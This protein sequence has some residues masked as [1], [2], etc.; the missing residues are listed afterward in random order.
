MKKVH[1][2]GGL[3]MLLVSV[4]AQTTVFG[5]QT[6]VPIVAESLVPQ[7]RSTIYGTVYGD[8]RRPVAE[9]YVELLD[10]V[11]STIRQVKTDYSGRFQFT[12]LVDGRYQVKIRPG[13]T[14]YMEHTSEVT[15][16]AVSSVRPSEG[17][18]SGGSDTQHLEIVLKLN[19]RVIAGP[20]AA[21]PSVIFVQD[22]PPAARKLY[23]EGVA[24]LRQKKETE[25]LTNL[26]KA[27]EVFPDYY[28]ALD[29]LGGEYAIRGTSDRS[30]LEAGLV[31]LTKAAEVNPRGFSSIFG[32]GWAQYQLGMNAEAIETL[33]RATSLYG[34][35]ADAYLW[36]GKALK[37]ASKPERAEA[38]FKRANELTNGKAADIHWQ[39]A[40]LYNEQKRYNDAANEM[41]LFLKTAPKGEDVEKIK[42]LVKQLRDKAAVK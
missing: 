23:G 6:T 36:L 42:N 21:A 34:K 30:Y 4:L 7:G 41:E 11:N 12:G 15:I 14:D 37:R 9:V 33:G 19:E 3:G 26:K 35:A 2:V 20:F 8:S 39:L 25:G 32:L 10:D 27:L 24:Y 22:V 38:A 1:L 29:R 40:G 5:K 13:S 17:A 16:A 28:Q 18:R 31:L